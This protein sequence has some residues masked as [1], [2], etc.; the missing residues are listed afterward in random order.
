MLQLVVLQP[1][2]LALQ[3]M[4]AN[5]EGEYLKGSSRTLVEVNENR[6]QMG[7]PRIQQVRQF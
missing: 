1:L 6:L 4:S 7:A 5:I 3:V 2:V